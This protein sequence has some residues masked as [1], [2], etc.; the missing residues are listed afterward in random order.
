MPNILKR[1]LKIR[2]FVTFLAVSVVAIS[3]L[4]AIVY[5]AGNSIMHKTISDD[6]VS[7]SQVA[8]RAIMSIVNSAKLEFALTAGDHF[9]AE[10][11]EKLIKKDPDS[12]RLLKA[13]ISYMDGFRSASPDAYEYFIVD[14]SGKVI[15]ATEE[16]RMGLDKSSDEYFVK[17]Q[18]ELHI[19]D[20]YKSPTT[21]E[22]GFVVSGPMYAVNSKELL[23]VFCIRYNMS[24]INA[25]TTDRIGLGKTGETYIVNKDGY[26]ITESR[27]IKDAE[28]KQKVESEPVRLWQTQKK[29]M[30]G[31]YPDYRGQPVLGASMG[32]DL[33][34]SIGDLGWLI[35]CEVD[36][37]EAFAPIQRLGLTILILG[38]II[39]IIIALIAYLIAQG[40]ANPITLIAQIA[41]KVG[42]GDLTVNVAETKAED[43]IGMLSKSIKQTIVSLRTIVSQV[44]ETAE[45]VSSSSQQLSSSAEEMNATTE[46]VSSTVQ[47]IARGSETTA[48]RVEEASKVMEQMNASVSQVANSAQ[49]TASASNQAAQVARKGGEAAKEAEQKMSRIY[50]TVTASGGM[51]KKLGERSEQINE[52]TD[53]ITNIADQTNLLA[54]NA[55]IEAARAGEQGR[56]FAVVAEEVRK[57]AESSAKAADQIARLIKDVQKETNQ[58][59]GAMDT[60]S[61]EV[62]EGREAVTKAA[63]ALG[64]IVQVVENTASMVEQISAATQQMSAGTKQVVKSVDDIASTAEEAASATEEASASTEEMTASMEEMA[65]SAQELS[66]MA[67]NLRALVGKFK[68]GEEVRVQ[69]TEYREQKPVIAK[70]PIAEKLLANRKNMEELRKRISAK[71]QTPHKQEAKEEKK[72]EKPEVEEKKA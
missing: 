44:L 68:V 62:T 12:Q 14:M 42:E 7:R 69:T 23:G 71:A 50:E 22:T 63:Q 51:I 45:R 6:Y 49:Q 70:K 41:Q 19:K 15:I 20:V 10:T 28:L 35:L 61:K 21:G 60:G 37:A 8:E 16:K 11:T 54:L 65:A 38:I 13:L 34:K 4:G 66:E 18:K 29:D 5:F 59:M 39:S 46:E 47:Q 48:Q 1:S 43:E 9:I 55:A 2:V 72:T 33:A 67:I 25:V 3:I 27:F 53:V 56:G 24:G 57:L 40:I 26:M 58:A 17:G 30:T 32:E 52:I 36:A 64:E 31:L